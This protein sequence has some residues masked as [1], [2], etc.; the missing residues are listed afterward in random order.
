MQTDLIGNSGVPLS[1]AVLM[2]ALQALDTPLDERHVLT[3]GVE[4]DAGRIYRV[5]RTS[6]L[7]ETVRIFE[8]VRALGFDIADARSSSSEDFQKVLRHRAP[9]AVC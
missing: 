6:G 4:D 1:D 3:L 2:R 8:S 5:V 9:T 7:C